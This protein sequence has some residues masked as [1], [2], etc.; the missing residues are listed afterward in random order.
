M[1]NIPTV[2]VKT[3]CVG[4]Y[5]F[6]GKHRLDEGGASLSAPIFIKG[7]VMCLSC[8]RAGVI[9]LTSVSLAYYCSLQS[10]PEIQSDSSLIADRKLQISEPFLGG[11]A[12]QNEPVCLL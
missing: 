4:V 7:A 8:L 10:L 5:L 1:L 9:R 6:F 11:G 2:P 3:L 12:I